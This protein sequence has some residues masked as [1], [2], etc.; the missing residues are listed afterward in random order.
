MKIKD[1]LTAIYCRLSSEDGLDNISVSIENQINI[2][3]QFLNENNLSL[4]NIYIDDGYTGSNF[5]RPGFQNMINDLEMKK[6]S[7]I[8]VK[9]LSR[10]GRNFLKASYY[11]EDYFVAK[12]IRFISINDN[13]DSKTA[14]NE[15]LNIAIKNFLNGYYAKE[16]SKKIRVAHNN[17]AKKGTLSCHG[18]YGLLVEDNTFLPDPETAPIVKVIFEKYLTGEK[19]T[20]ICK[21]LKENKI[22]TPSYY[23]NSRHQ[24]KRGL[25]KDGMYEWKTHSIYTILKDEQYTG[26]VVNF[27]YST[28]KYGKKL[29]K[30]D[31]SRWQKTDGMHEAIISREIYE[32]VQKLLFNRYTKNNKKH[33]LNKKELSLQG[34]VF[35]DSGKS[36]LFSGKF[37]KNGKL[38]KSTH[39]SNYNESIYIRSSIVHEIVFNDVYKVIAMIKDDKNKF[40]EM[41]KRKKIK[42]YDANEIY[43]VQKRLNEIDVEYQILFEKLVAEEIDDVEY[44]LSNQI[45]NDEVNALNT[46]SNELI[47]KK[48]M[49]ETF[50][51][52]INSFVNTIDEII[53]ETSQLKIIKALVS[54]IIISK[55]NDGFKF[56]IIYNFEN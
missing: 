45:L 2:C 54:K 19:V 25:T 52:K 17:R 35:T 47:A 48:K 37:D 8:V 7:C 28:P 18:H 9:D 36:L 12:R 27:K 33:E 3:K 55:I 30:S 31:K 5:D 26:T 14:D 10:L 16:C 42:D 1:T 34:M 6:I 24:T 49:I 20:S 23:F 46:K 43:R 29:N 41:V 22:L 13:Y 40:I 21:Y 15:E 4:Y 56:K 38:F 51:N 32:E 39:Y 44:E 53:N 11:I 50:I